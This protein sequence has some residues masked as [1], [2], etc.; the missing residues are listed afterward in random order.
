[1]ASC[2]SQASQEFDRLCSSGIVPAWIKLN[3]CREAIGQPPD[4]FGGIAFSVQKKEG[5]S[6]L[7]LRKRGSRIV[8]F[9][10]SLDMLQSDL[11]PV[12]RH[13]RFPLEKLGIWTTTFTSE[14]LPDGKSVFV[15]AANIDQH[16]QPQLEQLFY[17][18]GTPMSFPCPGLATEVGA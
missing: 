8:H 3:A 7:L 9:A 12:W 2:Q 15:D 5:G 1:M 14:I 4:E 6:C 10:G 18:K 17:R 11:A 13:R 16:E